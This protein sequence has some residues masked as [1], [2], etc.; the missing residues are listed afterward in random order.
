MPLGAPGYQ[1]RD[2]DRQAV[3]GAGHT[4]RIDHFSFL[5]HYYV[6]TVLVSPI[7]SN[8]PLLALVAILAHVQTSFGLQ[9]L[10]LDGCV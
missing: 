5:V 10:H 7:S 3:T 9:L 6:I 1:R 8:R 2:L 4:A